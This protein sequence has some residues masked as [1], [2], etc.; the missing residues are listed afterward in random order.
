MTSCKKQGVAF[1][2]TA[3]VVV[4]LL[5]YPIGFGPACWLTAPPRG[6]KTTVA[7]RVYWP[8]GWLAANGPSWSRD[9]VF[10]YATRGWRNRVVVPMNWDDTERF[11]MWPG[12]VLRRSP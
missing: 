2:A 11:A 6:G 1:W 12:P 8:I 3:V 10:W 7:P 9:V 5:A 4:A